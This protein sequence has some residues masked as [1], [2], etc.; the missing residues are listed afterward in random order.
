MAVKL[1]ILAILGRS[2][3]SAVH[4][5]VVQLSSDNLTPLNAR[6]PIR[7][8]ASGPGAYAVSATDRCSRR[9]GAKRGGRHTRAS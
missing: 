6:D 3:T 4:S 1:A 2:I 9:I 7:V 8:A 5:F